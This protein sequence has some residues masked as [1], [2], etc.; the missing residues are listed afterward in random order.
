ME[1]NQVDVFANVT[2]GILSSPGKTDQS[3]IPATWSFP[4]DLG[5]STLELVAE[6]DIA[7]RVRKAQ[8]EETL[9]LTEDTWVVVVVRWVGPPSR[10]MA[11]VLEDAGAQPFAFSNPIFV[12]ADGGGFD[13]PPLADLAKAP[14]PP[15]PPSPPKTRRSLTM[16]DLRKIADHVHEHDHGGQGHS[17]GSKRPHTHKRK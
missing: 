7:H 8:L 16:D 17:H 4:V 3:A 2:E 1:V 9:E 6:G 5:D 15:A 11:P 13:K 14:I 12:D 10:T